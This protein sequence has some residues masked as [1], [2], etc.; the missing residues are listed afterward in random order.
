MPTDYPDPLQR[1]PPEISTTLF[2]IV[3]MNDFYFP[4]RPFDPPAV[5]SLSQVCQSWREFV[6]SAPTLWN[7]LRMHDPS[8][9]SVRQDKAVTHLFDDPR[10][11]TISPPPPVIFAG[12]SLGALLEMDTQTHWIIRLSSLGTAG[13]PVSYTWIATG[14]HPVI[15]Q[16]W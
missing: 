7:A 15:I 11:R 1:L 16:V 6:C 10:S 2:Q 9:S 14:T 5:L 8:A 3:I 13:F 4:S 12:L